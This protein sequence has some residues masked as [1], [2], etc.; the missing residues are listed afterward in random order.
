MNNLNAK[1]ENPLAKRTM[2]R[3]QD[4]KQKMHKQDEGVGEVRRFNGKERPPGTKE[5]KRG[6]LEQKKR[7]NKNETKTRAAGPTTSRLRSF[8][9][10]MLETQ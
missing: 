4:E 2:K 1:T 9:V 8:P 10:R 5:N 3:N 7:E 6:K